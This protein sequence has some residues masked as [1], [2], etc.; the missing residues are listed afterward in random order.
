MPGQYGV[1]GRIV[2]NGTPVP[3]VVVRFMDDEPP[4][5][6]TTNQGGHYWF[7]SFAPGTSFTMEFSQMDNPPITPITS[8][9]S[10]AYIEG[11]LFTGDNVIDLPDL[12]ININVGGM[13]FELQAP[14]DGATYPAA[15][16]SSSNPVQFSWTTYN[17]GISYHV[18]L[19]ANGSRDP[20][21]TSS[22]T[23]STNTMWNGTLNN[24]NRIVEGA[25]W[26]RAGVK[27][28]VGNYTLFIFTRTSD[29]LFN[30]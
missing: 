27:K 19:G 23:T 20:I 13:F 9:A 24:G 6:N 7:T 1:T 21:W 2:Q 25:Y 10:L 11:S 12:D 18:E 3:N 22:E 16:I 14:V 29:I 15:V 30:P 17:Q 8:T 4:R 28:I 5:V 26:W